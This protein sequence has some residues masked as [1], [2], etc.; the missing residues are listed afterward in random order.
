M[1]AILIADREYEVCRRGATRG[2]LVLSDKTLRST[3]LT[4]DYRFGSAEPFQVNRV[5]CDGGNVPSPCCPVSL[6][7]ST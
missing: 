4:G 1:A 3:D 7:S 2:C 6:R 5:V